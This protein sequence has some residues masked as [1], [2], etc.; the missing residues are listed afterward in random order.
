MNSVK[1]IIAISFL[2]FIFTF[3]V[4]QE[5]VYIKK[6]EFFTTDE[7]FK[8]AWKNI[9][10]GNFLFYQHR[11]ASYKDA[12]PFYK[13]AIAYNTENA[14]LNLI[15]AICYLRSDPKAE[16]LKYI[17]KAI[18]QKEDVHEKANFFLARALHHNLEFAKAI[19]EYDAYKETLNG[20]KLKEQSPIIDKYI[21]ECESG[22][23]LKKKTARIIINNLGP[24]I[25]SAF[26]DYGAVLSSDGLRL[27]FT[28]RRGEKGDRINPMDDKYFE[29]IYTSDFV[30]S[31]WKE[32]ENIGKP[33][34]TDWNDAAVDFLDEKNMLIFYRGR[35][36]GG[37]LYTTL[38]KKGK[39]KNIN[40]I[41][42]KVN[43][44]KS[45][46]SAISFNADGTTM[47]FVS[48][49]D[50]DS[51]GGKDIYYCILDDKGKKW[52][53]PINIGDDIN[54]EFDEESVFIS[55]D[56]KTIYFSSKG[57]NTMGGYDIFISEYKYDSWTTPVNLGLPINTADD[58]LFMTILPNAR[59]AY[60]SAIRKEGF[61]S[62]DIY[63]ATIL[64]P[65]KPLLLTNE[66]ELLAGIATPIEESFIEE[67][68][69][70]SYT[71]MTI[72]K[73]SVTDFNTGTP[74]ASTIE[75]VDNATGK[76][77]KKTTSNKNTGSYLISLPSGKDY[78]FSANT[79]GYM[80]HSENFVVPEAQDYKEIF[81][82]IK[83][84]PITPGSKI[85]LH[86]TF[87]ETAKSTLR[88]ESFSELNRL[89]KMF[90]KSP[91][92]VIEIS[93]HTD[94]RGSRSANQRLSVAR[95]KSVVDYLK[96]QGVK[97][98]NLK[99]VGYNFKF[100]VASNKTKEGRQKNRRVEAK[101]LSN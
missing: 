56:E 47:Y 57:H 92:L 84:Q 100:P 33:V 58:D 82:D 95:A 40:S 43:S 36:R 74:L 77:I 52:S 6:K 16:A 54:S 50:D 73:G 62:F 23:I 31:G 2:T 30:D 65:E 94:S 66:D 17:Q 86:N 14:E 49:M 91:N 15:L 10:K 8:E 5:R 90:E 3:S 41:S 78:G 70:I 99:A 51:F 19:V 9:K 69:K 67:S 83:L 18:D 46:E 12:I 22:K 79:D 32:A 80:F 60:F 53:K 48:N 64:G 20:K 39:W 21:S 81:K 75:L 63:H 97:A 98:A 4:A 55:P 37:D 44:K 35:E 93:G 34:N 85:I 7:G 76:L 26:D 87:F 42:N 29:D 24:Q 28:S 45:K 1:F 27:V 96:A 11:P 68:M 72:V 61:G 89:A 88:T 71:R 38:Y 13:D 101:V 59:D 25:N